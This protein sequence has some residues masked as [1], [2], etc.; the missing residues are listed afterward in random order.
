MLLN[1]WGGMLLNSVKVKVASELESEGE[2]ASESESERTS[3][4]ASERHVPKLLSTD[5]LLIFA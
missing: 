5:S 2:S 4:R 1:E 3:A